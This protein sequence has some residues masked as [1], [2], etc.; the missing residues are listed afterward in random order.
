MEVCPGWWM[1]CADLDCE[2]NLQEFIDMGD[3][4]EGF[5]CVLRE[6]EFLEFC[7]YSTVD[8]DIPP[9]AELIET[10]F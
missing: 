10:K 7:K 6:E 8:E 4:E 9:E 1:T 3:G 5:G 2:D